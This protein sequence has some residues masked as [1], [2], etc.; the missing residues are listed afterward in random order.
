MSS[1]TC[2]HCG[3]D[4]IGKG[5]ELNDKFFCCNG[6]KSVYQLLSENHLDGFYAYE[7]QAG[8]RPQNSDNQKY[9]FLDVEDIRIKFIDFEDKNTTHT[10]LFLPEIHCSSCIYLLENIHKIESRIIS[11]Q[12]NFAKRE[13]AIIFSKEMKLSE[14]ANILTKIGYAPNFGNREEHK[15]KQSKTYLYKLGVAGF[16]FGSIMLWTFPEYFGIEKTNPEIRQFSAYLAFI[17]SIPVI[18]YSANEYF[19]SAFRAVRYKSIN[20]DVPIS[21]GILAL[22]FQSVYKIFSEGGTGYIDSFAGFVFFLLIGKWFQSKAYQSLSFERDYT[23]YF[24]VA[25]T[26]KTGAE[27]EIV[28]IDKIKIG[29]CIVIRNQEVITCD[30]KL[31]SESIKIDYSF[32]T[33][34][35]IPITKHKGDFIY[36][37]GKLVGKKSEFTVEKESTRSHLTQLWNEVNKD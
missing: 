9:A 26:R 24:P 33:G 16:A 15:K 20:L 10:T 35:S 14:L 7:S 3:D 19:I 6:C 30:S 23:A 8:V 4:V 29:E 22:Y 2:Y 13:A 21:L 1:K 17:V 11:C 28:E 36:A 25:V 5:I 18:L 32:V 34:E 37:G 31:L 12:V 27:E